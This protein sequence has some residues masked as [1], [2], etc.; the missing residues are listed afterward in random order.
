MNIMPKITLR[1]KL[2]L[3][4]LT[5]SGLIDTT[6]NQ[7]LSLVPAWQKYTFIA[8]TFSAL[9]ENA[10]K[11]NSAIYACCEALAF[12]F[13]EPKL[14]VKTNRK[15]DMTVDP[16][17]PVAK[18]LSA[19]NQ[20]MGQAELLQFAIVYAALGGNCYFYKVRSQSGKVLALYPFSD[21]HITPIVG[22][23]T[24][25]GLVAAYELDVGDGNKMII[26]KADMI[27]WRFMPDPAQPARGMGAVVAAA[28]EVDTDNEAT[29]Y[30]FNL[31]KNDATPRLA[32]TLSPEDSL[33]E[34]KARRLRREWK[35]IFGSGGSEKSG[36]AFLESGMKIEKVGLNMQ[37]LAFTA[38][39]A[40]PEARIASN[41]RVPPII[42]GLNV[43][44]ERS[45]FSNYGEARQAFTED[46]LAPLWRSLASELQAGLS[47]D[48][49]GGEFEISFDLMTVRALQ[50]D[51][52]KLWERVNAAFTGGWI[53]R[54]DARRQVNLPVDDNQ[55]DVYKDELS[56]AAVL[57]LN[58]EG[59]IADM[60]R[61]ARRGDMVHYSRALQRVR[62]SVAG[63]MANKVD[64]FFSE[65]SG[66]VEQRLRDSD[67]ALPK[68]KGKGAT[69]AVI[70]DPNNLI[71][72]A[73]FNDLVEI[74]KHYYIEV[75]QA[76]WELLNL[77][78]GVSVAFDLTD[79]IITEALAHAG[80]RIRQVTDTTLEEVRALLQHANEN[81]WSIDHIVAGDP[82]SGV[83][84]MRQV[85]EETYRNRAR[86]IARTE[87]GT[88]QNIVTANRFAEA[89]VAMVEILDNGLDD[90]DEPCQ[91]ANGQI[92]TVE[93]FLA[94]PLEDR[95]SVV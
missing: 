10:Y 19:P 20:D 16:A 14:I 6:K 35:T 65:L 36:V 55:D 2:A 76:S 46:T 62:K 72:P 4:V 40:V 3:R 87:L 17:H 50:P 49:T 66:L 85:V 75:A 56:A 5:R 92:W 32:V 73:D 84:G 31:L 93:Y 80:T 47:K 42:A 22:H 23:T 24:N 39:K 57:P 43:G 79:P 41:F 69:K 61:R 48:F 95:K 45:T 90:D 29:A 88:A 15:G 13:P 33:T 38:L 27:Q 54:A 34:D 21:G 86:A 68:G 9:I 28:K 51:I 18:L 37:E 74:Y 25:E 12:A 53:T 52:D 67:Y 59:R 94:H 8:P 63:R 71:I 60:K 89:G 81:G 70:P 7:P 11:A 30:I 26:P 77:S 78:L 64:L 83:R 58:K 44:L 1:D 82:D 91:V